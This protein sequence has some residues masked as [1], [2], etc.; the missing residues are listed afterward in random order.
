MVLKKIFFRIR[1]RYNAATSILIIQCMDSPLHESIIN[2]AL[3][4]ISA[5]IQTLYYTQRHDIGL[6]SG[7][8]RRPSAKGWTGS[9]IVPDLGLHLSSDED[10]RLKWVM[11]VGVLQ[12]HNTNL[13]DTCGG[14]LQR[15]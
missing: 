1:L 5:W 4:A 2:S 3:M 12:A 9:K 14:A 8:D 7:V 6:V 10:A 11:E 13:K 15:R